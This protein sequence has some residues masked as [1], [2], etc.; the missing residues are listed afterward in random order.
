MQCTEKRLNISVNILNLLK[1]FEVIFSVSACL[2]FRFLGNRAHKPSPVQP[3]LREANLDPHYEHLVY[4]LSSGKDQ[5]HR[6]IRLRMCPN[7]LHLYA[8]IVTFPASHPA[9]LQV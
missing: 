4:S 1:S 8:K 2:L 5:S 7:I 6:Q 3:R 9:K